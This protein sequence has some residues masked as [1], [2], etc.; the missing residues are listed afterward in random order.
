MRLQFLSK[1][2]LIAVQA[3]DRKNNKIVSLFVCP[4]RL[5]KG[6]KRGKVFGVKQLRR[7]INCSMFKVKC[8]AANSPL[9]ELTVGVN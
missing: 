3:E 1:K 9:N 4:L 5:G 7:L 2:N 6:K 8:S